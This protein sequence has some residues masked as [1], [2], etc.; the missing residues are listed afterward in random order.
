ML[1]PLFAALL[2]PHARGFFFFRFKGLTLHLCAALLTVFLEVER[3]FL[4]RTSTAPH[5]AH[6]VLTDC[7]NCVELKEQ[8]KRAW[9]EDF[10]SQLSFSVSYA[11]LRLFLFCFAAPHFRE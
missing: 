10:F 5:S 2:F 7:R 4:P 1:T 11:H 6:L 8:E 9:E 3:G